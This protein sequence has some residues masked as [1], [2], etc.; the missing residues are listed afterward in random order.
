MIWVVWAICTMWLAAFLYIGIK[1]WRRPAP[2]SEEHEYL[3]LWLED[4]FLVDDILKAAFEAGTASPGGIQAVKL[5]LGRMTTPE[6]RA[7]VAAFLQHRNVRR[8]VADYMRWRYQLPKPQVM[9]R[10]NELSEMARV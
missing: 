1:T 4:W 6:L 5:R 2:V 8:V 3:R 7:A 9:A 10:L